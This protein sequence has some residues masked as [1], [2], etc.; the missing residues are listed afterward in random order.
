MHTLHQYRFGRAILS[1]DML[2]TQCE[3]EGFRRICYYPDRPD[4]MSIFT[5][6][7]EADLQYKQLLCNGNKVEDGPVGSDRH[8]PYGMTRIPSP[9][10]CLLWLQ[11]TWLLR[12]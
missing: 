12:R 4:V 5:V 2:C 7:I 10:I 6:R 8:L 11:A 1:G 3:P 9:V